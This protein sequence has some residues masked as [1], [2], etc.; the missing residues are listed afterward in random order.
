MSAFLG[1]ETGSSV[2]PNTEA[3]EP[4]TRDTSPV[5]DEKHNSTSKKEKEQGNNE[6]RPSLHSQKSSPLPEAAPVLGAVGFVSESTGTAQAA[7]SAFKQH[8]SPPPA[9]SDH[10]INDEK[11]AHVTTEENGSTGIEPV[12]R[13]KG[14]NAGETA[15]P[16]EED[17][18][19]V[20]PGGFQLGILTFG[21]CMSTFMIALDN[22]IIGG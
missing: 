6:R 16:G 8:P 21:L 17:D 19:I 13:N 3:E 11:H 18:E 4:A 20:Y 7:A 14:E 12:A 1:K 5:D 2:A 10:V 9:H 15:A 22:T